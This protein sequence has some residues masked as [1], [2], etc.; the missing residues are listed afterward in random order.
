[1]RPSRPSR[2][3]L[4]TL[5]FVLA[6][7]GC[8]SAP[9][10]TPSPS[11]GATSGNV[12]ISARGIRFEQASVDVPAGAAFK[13]DF[14]NK[15]P[16]TPHDIFIHSGDANGPVV[17]QG[18]AFVGPMVKTYDVPALGPGTYTFVCSIHPGPMVGLMTA[19]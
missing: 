11:V 8:T 18:E 1:M 16:S 10:V 9:A 5:S 13:I 2:P 12:Q 14:D 4:L 3:T 19:R 15:D 7:A 6:L 17:F